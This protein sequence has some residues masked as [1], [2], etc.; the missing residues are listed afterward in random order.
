MA[1]N[2]LLL[3]GIPEEASMVGYAEDV[4]II[5][6]AHLVRPGTGSIWALLS[7]AE[8]VQLDGGARIVMILSKSEVLVLIKKNIPIILPL[9]IDDV[10]V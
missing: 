7:I 1:D 3:V 2:C 5:F 9:R 4:S 10:T 6:V 8:Y